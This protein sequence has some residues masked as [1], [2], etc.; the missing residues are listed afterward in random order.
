MVNSGHGT[1]F[2][3]AQEIA[4]V[5]GGSEHLVPVDAAA[6]Q[7]KAARPQFAALDNQRLA[8]ADYAMPTWQDA[9]GRYLSFK[10][11]S[12]TI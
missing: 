5:I 12:A 2:E 1:W 8:A 10:Q 9:L 6:L 3:V 7:L 4:R 11:R